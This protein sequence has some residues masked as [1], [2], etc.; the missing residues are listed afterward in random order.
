MMIRGS[1]ELE[2]HVVSVERVVEYTHLQSEGKVTIPQNK[3][4][5]LWPLEGRVEFRNYSASYRPQLELALK[6]LT[7]H[8]K[9]MEKVKQ[10]YT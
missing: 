6:N 7:F 2:T 9:P 5:D 3:M 8:I 10:L 4:D 1:C